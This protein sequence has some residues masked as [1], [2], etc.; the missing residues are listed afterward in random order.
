MA[1]FTVV[2]EM[3]AER[4][5]L[6]IKKLKKTPL[7]EWPKRNT[8]HKASRRA[9]RVLT[10]IDASTKERM[11]SHMTGWPNCAKASFWEVTSVSTKPKMT[12]RAVR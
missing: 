8:N 9:A 5:T 3:K 2:A 6:M 11:L 10:N 1:A 4:M 12:S 7:A